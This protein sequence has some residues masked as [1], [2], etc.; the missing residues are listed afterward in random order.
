MFVLDTDH[1]TLL[2][3]GSGPVGQRL[4]ERIRALPENEVVT[5]VITYEEQTRGWMAY[6]ARAKTTAQQVEAYRKLK[7]HLDL[8]CR[9]QLLEFDEPAGVE[10]EQ[11]Q[12]LRPRIGTMD[13]KIAAI[14]LANNATVLTR[15]IQDF[16]RVPGL[17]V[18][19]WSL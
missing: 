16:V 6:A 17:G 2:E 3:W 10:F 4:H 15:N 5:T 7:R 19:D 8:Y 18:E 14:A 1:I 11:L 12:R 13:L 9:L